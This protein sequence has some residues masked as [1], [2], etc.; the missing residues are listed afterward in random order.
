MMKNDIL[1]RGTIY[2]EQFRL[3][4]TECAQSVQQ[5]R[6]LHDLSPLPSIFLGRLIV[7]AILMSGELKAPKSELSIR[8]EGDGP[9][10]GGIA[11]ADKA[12]NIRAYAFEPQ[13]WLEPATENLQVGKN[14]GKGLLTIMKQSGLKS[15]YQGTIELISG[16]IAEDLAQYYL[17]SEQVPSAVN[18]GVLIDQHANIRSAGG[19]IIQQMPFADPAIADMI[20]QNL[21]NTPNVSDLLDMGMGMPDIL[22]R[23]VLKDVEWKFTHQHKL[24]YHCNCS[25]ERFAQALMLLGKDELMEMTAGISPQCHYCSKIYDFTSTEIHDLIIAQEQ[26][27]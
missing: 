22:N 5:A 23:F 13:L 7:A 25:K 6:D 16:E 1:Y 17:H 26:N 14:L 4:A 21:L 20:N 11:L 24:R 9:L 3:F 18:L 2:Q 8:V 12:G 27:K 19:F 10:K 15:P